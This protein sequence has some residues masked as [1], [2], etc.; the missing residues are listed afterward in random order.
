MNSKTL[1]N[2]MKSSFNTRVINLRF[3]TL[4]FFAVSL[5]FT[6]CGEEEIA[7]PPGL[8]D[9]PVTVT[10]E[11]LN[12]GQFEGLLVRLDSVQFATTGVPFNGTNSNANGSKTLE[13][14]NGNATIVFTSTDKLF[15]NALT[16]AGNG[17]IIGLASSFGSTVQLLLRSLEDVEG[18]TNQRC[19]EED[20]S[21]V[22]LSTI[23]NIRSQFSGTTT[24]VNGSLKIQGVITSDRST[25]NIQG[26]NAFIQDA[27]GAIALRF[28]E[29]H[30]F[31]LGDEV[32]IVVSN[33]EL[34]E[35][36]ELLQLNNIPNG[37]ANLIGAGTLPAPQVVSISD[38]LSENFESQLVQI[39]NI[40]FENQ[41]GAYDGGRTLTDCTDD[42]PIFT[43]GQATFSADITPDGNGT[44]VGIAS[45]FNGVQ[46]LIR[47][48]NDV[49]FNN[50]RVDCGGNP[51]GGP[52]NDFCSTGTIAALRT[53]YQGSDLTVSCTAGGTATITG[54]VS[55]D[56][57]EGNINNQNIFFQDTTA[58][59]TVRFDG[60]HSF[61][62]GDEL[63]I[64]LEGATLTDF[65]DLVQIEVSLSNATLN[66]S[67][68]A[69]TPRVVTIAELNTGN[70]ESQLVQINNVTFT[71][72]GQPLFGG[73]GSGTNREFS[74]GTG[75]G[76]LRTNDDPSW[77]GST[78]LPSGSDNIV[79]ANAS[80]FRGAV[81]IL[82]RSPSDLQKP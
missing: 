65:N 43:R 56:A 82:L 10:I 4:L 71:E 42:L 73:S 53:L 32:E 51:G 62:P 66:S 25:E 1:F 55:S 23:A 16:P 27:S 9:N 78:N 41:G 80:T 15:S 18:M 12:S 59:I 75:T 48:T 5:F 33:I 50:A 3:Y 70:F 45:T 67:G 13:D 49:S 7:P 36:N 11:E 14:C 76:T 58:G 26:R 77:G 38:V 28:T 19:G 22:P 57:A 72:A 29:D 37:N 24:N 34:S 68:N 17:S 54:L 61:N 31:D 39:N 69:I 2:Y 79:I 63:T 8:V 46:L 60:P 74:D 47:N 40:Q 81:Q 52:S 35:F 44:I 20:P 30:S 6:S 21:S 64:N